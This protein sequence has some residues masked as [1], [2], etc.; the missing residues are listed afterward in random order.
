MKFLIP[1]VVALLMVS[2]GMS[3]NLKELVATLRRLTWL[4]WLR[5]LLA[6]FI[7]PATLALLLGQLFRLSRP[8]LAG[9]FLV[10]VAPGAPLLTR[11]LAKKGF[12]MHLA[13]TY[14]VWAALM[15]PIMIPLVVA[16]AAKLYNRNIWIPPLE[17]IQQIAE[18]QL[19]PL[20]LGML[21]AKLAPKGSGRW[22]PILNM[23]GNITLTIVLALVLFKLGP[24]LKAITPTLPVVCLLL[25]LGSIAAVW[26][27][28][29]K[30]PIVAGTFA[31]SNANRHVGLAVLLSGEYVRAR[32][33]AVPPI[34][35]YAL[36]APLVM[37]V[38]ARLYGR[39][40][41]SARGVSS[42]PEKSLAPD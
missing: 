42:E 2:I 6:T 23:I 29:L 8:E 34:A 3:L 28:R 39:G 7:L 15:I 20:A 21:I 11:N 38:Y 22:Q 18:K 9:I 13:A 37:I 19:L 25:A 14:Q 33:Q 5:M 30:D 24:A 40:T 31:I 17:L 12:D 26:L 41:L 32:Q 36:M 10:G 27:M 35:C 4:A 1:G 16:A